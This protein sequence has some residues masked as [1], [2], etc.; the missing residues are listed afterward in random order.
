MATRL[1]EAD[2]IGFPL[3]RGSTIHRQDGWPDL[4]A[5][6]PGE[7]EKLPK[8]QQKAVNVL[9]SASNLERG[10]AGFLSSEDG[11]LF[12]SDGTPVVARISQ[13]GQTE[14]FVE[15]FG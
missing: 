6:G 14:T 12:L 9:L 3:D 2:Q 11:T 5:V 10:L 13:K 4:I 7:L 15:W 8:P 1:L